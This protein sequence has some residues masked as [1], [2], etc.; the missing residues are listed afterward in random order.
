MQSSKH[1]LALEDAKTALKLPIVKTT[2]ELYPGCYSTRAAAASYAADAS[3]ALG[4]QSDFVAF[5][6]MAT[7]LMKNDA[8]K[9]EQSEELKRKGNSLFSEGNLEQALEAYKEAIKLDSSN[10]AAFSNA[11]LTLLKLGKANEALDMAERCIMLRPEWVKGYYRKGNALLSLEKYSEAVFSFQTGL[12]IS[13]DDSELKQAYMDAAK[14]ANIIPNS[15][16][17]KKQPYGESAEAMSHAKK[18]MGMMM[19]LK[20]NS[21]DVKKFFIEGNPNMLDFSR[22]NEDI[23]PLLE[24][25]KITEYI[26]RILRIGYPDIKRGESPVGRNEFVESNLPRT[27]PNAYV[28]PDEPL[29][30]AI[31]FFHLL[32]TN[33]APNETSIEDQKHLLRKS[34]SLVFTHQAQAAAFSG[35]PL[36]QHVD[37]HKT[38]AVL[39]DKD[40]GDVLDFLALYRG[41]VAVEGGGM[42]LILKNGGPDTVIYTCDDWLKGLEYVEG[43]YLGLNEVG[44]SD[45]RE[46]KSECDSS[47]TE[48]LEKVQE[49]IQE[50]VKIVQD[51]KDI[52]EISD[53]P[54][55]RRGRIC[56]RLLDEE[57]LKDVIAGISLFVVCVGILLVWQRAPLGP[58]AIVAAA[59]YQ[60]DTASALLHKGFADDHDVSLHSCSRCVIIQ[61][62]PVNIDSGAVPD[63]SDPVSSIEIREYRH[64]LADED[65]ARAAKAAAIVAEQLQTQQSLLM[66]AIDYQLVYALHSFVATLEGQVCVLKGDP[67]ALLDDTNSYWWLVRCCK[68]DEIGYIPAENIET[69]SERTARLNRIRNV[70]LALVTTD[71]FEEIISM[72]VSKKPLTF[73]NEPDVYEEYFLGEE[74]YDEEDIGDDESLT[75]AQKDDGREEREPS[76]NDEPTSKFT[77]SPIPQINE[78]DPVLSKRDDSEKRN[79]FWELVRKSIIAPDRGRKISMDFSKIATGS[80]RARSQS[81]GRVSAI[82]KED[83]IGKLPALSSPTVG[84]ILVTPPSTIRVLRIYSGNVDLNATFK[85]VTY[86]EETTVG[87]LLESAL[88][89]FKV[90]GANGEYYLSLIHFD[91]QDRRLREQDNVHKLLEHLSNKKLPGLSTSKK[92]IKILTSGGASTQNNTQIHINDEQ[93]IKIIIN[94]NASLVELNDMRLLR[95]F[96]IDSYDTNARTYKTVSVSADMTITALVSVAYKKFK[97]MNDFVDNYQMVTVGNKH[98]TVRSPYE[99]VRDVLIEE[100]GQNDFFLRKTGN[101]E[102]GTELSTVNMRTS[103]LHSV[104]MLNN[105]Q[106]IGRTDALTANNGKLVQ[107][108]NSVNSGSTLLATYSPPVNS[109]RGLSNGL[110]LRA[111]TIPVVQARNRW[112]YG[113]PPLES[114]NQRESIDSSKR[115]MI[116]EKYNDMERALSLL[117]RTATDSDTP[118]ISP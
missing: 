3:R 13:P 90:T 75:A 94:K 65:T 45:K 93:I 79:S 72:A 112:S 108:T 84:P 71:D 67:L 116:M 101:F 49:G 81:Q 18:M 74:Y 97:I 59:D 27:S 5:K 21:W 35:H 95:V 11:S 89:R 110:D 4:N 86:T 96:M 76:A 78:A 37:V 40:E 60:A 20:Y 47:N 57:G 29:I 66:Q 118:P 44:I 63:S 87:Q 12:K 111:S 104:G 107:L 30:S 103:S 114:E 7:E 1:A 41:G 105:R 38:Y 39:V 2:V 69:P 82:A 62:L 92:V 98:E 54:K 61:A 16:E 52:K 32:T 68:T 55:A 117:E 113:S 73:A 22:W 23:V 6:R 9:M 91:S 88:K 17:S 42:S 8:S 15:T 14:A 24:L 51:M 58:D 80:P 85:A 25:P 28:L 50:R 19:D 26:E 77:A 36:Q 100:G 64:C 102:R 99:L 46:K 43:Y 109:Q 10:S 34:W 115:V 53:V 33:A 56:C 83:I 31:L 70:Q 48:D 106:S